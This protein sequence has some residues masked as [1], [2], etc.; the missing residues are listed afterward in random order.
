M[1]IGFNNTSVTGDHG[2]NSFREEQE[3][4][5]TWLY[6][7]VLREKNLRA[8]WKSYSVFPPSGLR[9]GFHFLTFFEVRAMRLGIANEM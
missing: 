6:I 3:A 4:R 7:D 5:K 1:L 9:V 8:M 2:K